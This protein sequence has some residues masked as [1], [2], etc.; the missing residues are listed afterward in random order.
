MLPFFY[1][2]GRGSTLSDRQEA[3]AIPSCTFVLDLVDLV[4]VLLTGA[5][6][7]EEC[8]C[9]KL[10]LVLSSS[11]KKKLSG[12]AVTQHRRKTLLWHM[13]GSATCPVDDL[14]FDIIIMD[15]VALTNRHEVRNLTS[16]SQVFMFLSFIYG[17]AKPNYNFYRL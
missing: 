14:S 5:N 15:Q 1:P 17:L 7:V 12:S 3:V 11:P 6:L 8:S 10:S 4:Y 16:L 13:G 2:T 9:L